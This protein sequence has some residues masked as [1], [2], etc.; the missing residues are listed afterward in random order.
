MNKNLRK[1]IAIAL[2]ITAFNAFTPVANLGLTMTNAYAS[3]GDLTSIKLKDSDGYTINTYSDDDYKSKNKVDYD[4]L[5]TNDTYYAKTSSAKIEVDTKGVSSSHVRI[6]KGKGSSTKGIKPSKTM[7]LSED[8]TTT[9]TIRTYDDD[10]GTV[11]YSDDSY[12]GEYIIKVKCTAN[13][14]NSTDSTEENGDVYLRSL[15]LSDGDFEF[16]KTTSTY[17]VNVGESVDE[18]KITA[19]PDCDSD[20]YDDYEVTIDGYTVDESD[21]FKR[22]VSLEKGKNEIKVTVEDDESNKRTYILNITRSNN[23]ANVVNGDTSASTAVNTNIVTTLKTNQWVTVN[24]QWQYN[25]VMGNPVKNTW[26]GKYYLNPDGKMLTGW[27]FINGSWYYLGT[28]GAMKTN[29]QLIG[30]NWYYIDSQGKMQTGWFKDKDG[31]YYYLYTNG[32]MAS[33]TKI[34]GYKLGSN[35]AWI[36]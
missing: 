22:T 4:E 14:S 21:K 13:S 11:K 3:S 7:D 9:L 25:D 6:F 33:N 30:G 16:S 17:N 34:N 31:R 36:K 23:N 5:D 26:I 2:T 20:E 24:G 19:K 10:P 28:D 8:S 12:S 35:G 15:Y 29:W 27:Q 32:V 18:V 1:I